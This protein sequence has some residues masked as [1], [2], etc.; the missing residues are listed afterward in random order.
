MN[1]KFEVLDNSET[2]NCYDEYIG[3]TY[4]AVKDYQNTGMVDLVTEDGII[5][6]FKDIEVKEVKLDE[7]N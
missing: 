2:R 3:K 6:F 5:T 7:C 4:I 1:R